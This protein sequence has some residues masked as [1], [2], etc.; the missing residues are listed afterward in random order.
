MPLNDADIAN[1]TLMLSPERLAAL[2]NLTGSA[3]VAVELHQETLALSAS[4]MNVIASIEI[5]LRNSVSENLS[6][7]FGNP[8]WL[9]NPPA[10]F[11]WKIE[12]QKKIVMA[13]NS[14]RRAEYSKLTNAEKVA[15]D[16]LAFPQGMPPGLSHIRKVGERKK[17]ISVTQGKI[18]AELTIYFWKRLY[19]P[20]Y[21]Q[22]LWR[23]T[24]KKTF[25][26]KHIKRADIAAN[27]ENIYQV[28][29]RLAHHEP[30]LHKRFYDAMASIKYITEAMGVVRIGPDTALAKLIAD[31]VAALNQQAKELHDKLAAYRT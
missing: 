28:R 15:L 30:V 18:I 17:Q 23:T 8:S 5:S 25:P 20:D 22:R 9:L 10:N 27:L 4:L 16:A 13:V 7:Y 29:N 2:M 19:S 31:D 21:E 26:N 24:L 6:N 11:Q 12:E 14:A 3:R 1:V